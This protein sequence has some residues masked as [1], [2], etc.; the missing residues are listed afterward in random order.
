MGI[1]KS[2]VI[3]SYWFTLMFLYRSVPAK[4]F[5]V[6][7]IH[8]GDFWQGQIPDDFCD[9]GAELGGYFQN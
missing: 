8:G 7:K 3:Y 9:H 1:F 2:F 4:C 6:K 5:I